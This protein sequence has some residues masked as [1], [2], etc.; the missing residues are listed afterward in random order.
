M[1][2]ASGAIS[3]FVPERS[4]PILVQPSS[5]EG[6][7]I[8]SLSFHEGGSLLA[9]GSADGSVRLWDVRSGRCVQQLPVHSRS[10]T[11]LAFGPSPC[12]PTFFSLP[13]P[14]APARP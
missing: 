10:L 6:F 13:P 4:D 7:P 2:A 12:A 11:A 5:F 9:A 14:T 8:T 3:L 1:A